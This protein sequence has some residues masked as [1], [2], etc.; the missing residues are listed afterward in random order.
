MYSG[1]LCSWSGRLEQAPTAHSFRTDIISLQKHAQDTPYLT[2]LFHRLTYASEITCIVSGGAL[3]STHSLTD[4]NCSRV[5]AANIIRRPCID[6]SHVTAS[7][8]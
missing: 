6:S 1:I 3:N 4:Y 2:F 7:Y 5:R 8:E